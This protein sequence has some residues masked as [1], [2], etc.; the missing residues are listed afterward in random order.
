MKDRSRRRT[1]LMDAAHARANRRRFSDRAAAVQQCRS[2]GVASV[3]GGAW[4]HAVAAHQ[5]AR[6]DLRAA[7]RRRGDHRLR[8]QQIIA[9]ET[10]V[11]KVVDPFGGSYFV[12]ALTDQMESRQGLHR[13][14]RRHGRHRGRG[15][16]RLSATARS[17]RA[18]IVFSARSKTRRKSSLASTNMGRETAPR[19]TTRRQPSRH[20]RS[21]ARS[22]L[23]RLPG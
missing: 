8:T 1:A 6:R 16:S 15:R 13:S 12:E 2:R 14:H 4:R 11:A 19:E 3:G 9:D 10:G 20:S 22:K 7:D 21:I 17:P 18:P 23:T 5:F